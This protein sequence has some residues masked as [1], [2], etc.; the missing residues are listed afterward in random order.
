MISVSA[1]GT[2][3]IR[4]RNVFFKEENDFFGHCSRDFFYHICWRI[5]PVSIRQ[6]F[7]R[8]FFINFFAYNLMVF[9]TCILHISF[10]YFHFWCQFYSTLINIFYEFIEFHRE[11]ETCPSLDNLPTPCIISM[12]MIYR[13]KSY[14]QRNQCSIG[15]SYNHNL[16]R[17]QKVT[18]ASLFTNTKKKK[19]SKIIIEEYFF[20]LYS[21][22]SSKCHHLKGS[23][24]ILVSLGKNDGDLSSIERRK[25]D[26]THT[27]TC[28]TV[29]RMIRTTVTFLCVL[30]MLM[31]I[32]R[33]IYSQ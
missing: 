6:T 23:S 11:K 20:F 4:D 27:H 17:W 16:N 12:P 32:A 24:N 33:E 1:V 5:F 10:N 19:H 29:T 21:C 8:R 13:T 31:M 28:Q 22:F 7:C 26:H 15:G 9:I 3:P 25:M 2:V 18:N 14:S 30:K